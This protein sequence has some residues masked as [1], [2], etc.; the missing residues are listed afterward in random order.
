[1]AFTHNSKIKQLW[2]HPVGHD[3]LQNLLAQ[4][5]RSERWP[6][7]LLVANLPLKSLDRITG[8]PSF[9]DSLLEL[10][11]YDPGRVAIPLATQQH[12]WKEAVFYQLYL[13]S[14]MASDHD[15]VGDLAGVIKRLPYLSQLGVNALWPLLVGGLP[16]V[17]RAHRGLIGTGGPSGHHDAL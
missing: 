3:M 1:M 12:W 14:F 5:G 15:G 6:E 17:C 2:A 13:P 10:T 4:L 16:A 7:N 11:A 8:G 9:V